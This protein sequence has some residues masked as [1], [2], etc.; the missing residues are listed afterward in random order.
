MK[1]TT[2]NIVGLIE[3]YT[4]TKEVELNMI[5]KKSGEDYQI[6]VKNGK[7]NTKELQKGLPFDDVEYILYYYTNISDNSVGLNTICLNEIIQK[8]RS[9]KLNQLLNENKEHN[10]QR[11][12]NTDI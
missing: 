6:W 4:G 3:D 10:T 1:I 7:Y 8:L 12:R 5:T 9:E 2:D 11:H